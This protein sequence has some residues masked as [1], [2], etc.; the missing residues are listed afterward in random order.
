MGRTT[1]D[2]ETFTCPNTSKAIMVIM[3]RW[4]SIMVS[5]IME[6]TLDINTICLQEGSQMQ[7]ATSE[8]TPKITYR[9]DMVRP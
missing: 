2:S 6:V 9:M 7:P 4:A 1:K 8:I 3:A 5:T